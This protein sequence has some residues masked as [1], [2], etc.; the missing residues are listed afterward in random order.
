MVDIRTSVYTVSSL[1]GKVQLKNYRLF[2]H[3]LPVVLASN[4]FQWELNLDNPRETVSLCALIHSCVCMIVVNT[5]GLVAY[6]VQNIVL[7]VSCR[8]LWP[9]ST[10]WITT[11]LVSDLTFHTTR[12]SAF[13][14]GKRV[15]GSLKRCALQ[16][17][18]ISVSCLGQFLIDT[19]D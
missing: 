3:S 1:F 19:K 4:R 14:A 13:E 9:C 7:R 8:R 17:D 6:D 12:T 18:V 5:D 2:E 15:H 11:S 10:C 16:L